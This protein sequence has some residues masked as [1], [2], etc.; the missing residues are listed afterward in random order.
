MSN[1]HDKEL[2]KKKDEIVESRRNLL[3]TLGVGAIMATSMT[4]PKENAVAAPAVANKHLSM[5]IDLRKCVGCQ[6]CTTS[7]KIEN[8]VPEG[9][10]RTW[11]EDKEIGT[12]PN[13]K[14]GFLPHV[15]NQCDSPACTP[16][17]PV[18]A[19]YKRKED[20]AVV[21]EQEKCIGCGEC[22]KA[23]PYSARF[24]STSTKKADKCLLCGQRTDQNLLPACVENCTG[25]AR[26]Y[27]DLNDA[28]SEISM[29]VKQYKPEG[30]SPEFGVKP[31]VL[32][33]GLDS[34]LK[35]GNQ[36]LVES[37]TWRSEFKATFGSEPEWKGYK[38]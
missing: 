8:N 24:L 32:Y 10:F 11:V 9:Q 18:G 6:S 15:C 16:V 33:I 21:I 14:R 31:Q 13:T 23:C 34:K 25:G 1:N 26:I 4:M 37:N 17:C 36:L 7:C 38:Y 19:T 12:Y 5:L 29:L 22:V 35:G 20:Q 27:G 28:N 3:K 30:L 2:N